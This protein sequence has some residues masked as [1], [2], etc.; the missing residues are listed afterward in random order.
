[1]DHR[2][3]CWIRL[4][5]ALGYG[6][7]KP[8]EAYRRHPDLEKWFASR[9]F[10]ENEEGLFT[11]AEMERFQKFTGERCLKIAEMAKSLGQK[12]LTPE[13][14]EYPE[15]LR[16]I[17]NPPAVL[18][19][20]GDFPA[21]DDIPAIAVVGS[22]NTSQ[23]GL[24]AARILCRQLGAAGAVVVSGGALG[25]DTAAHLGAM[26]AGGK[27]VALLA[28]GIDYPYLKSNQKLREA[29]ARHGALISEFAPGTEVQK[30]HFLI[31]NRIIS[32]LSC[33]VL[34]AEASI[35]SGTMI[36][37][38]HATEQ[39]R[40][41]FVLMVDSW[42]ENS[43]GVLQLIW[44]GAKPVSC[45]AD[46]LTEYTPRFPA[47]TV[48]P[49]EPISTFRQPVPE[50]EIKGIHAFPDFLAESSSKKQPTSCEKMSPEA[51]AL[52][53]ALSAQPISVEELVY[54]TGMSID[55]L[56]QAATELELLEKIQ[57]FSGG[58]YAKKG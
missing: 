23:S 46:I 32:G 30:W 4:Q 27:T 10:A 6:S 31:R 26:D 21:V 22:R 2:L 44:D 20:V 47:C 24:A 41:I 53:Q 18:Y 37:A 48:P 12:M 56:F 52:Y 36:T 45:A 15:C 8:M 33:G 29:V 5:Q 58:R 11:K 1:M 57:S 28:C 50:D 14:S 38:K 7:N 16:Q 40:D 39:N 3:L 43:E 49:R 25:I 13:S 19:Y 54:R 9:S 17:A 55:K 35:K 42:R 51:K 34:V